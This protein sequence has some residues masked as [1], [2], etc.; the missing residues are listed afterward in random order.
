MIL[1]A[2]F[3]NASANIIHVVLM[4]YVWIVII[5][6]VLSWVNVPSL[7][8]VAIIL[9]YLTEPVMRPFRRIIPPQRLGGLDITPVIVILLILFV[10]SFI[11]KSISLYAQQLLREHA[12]SF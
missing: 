4:I 10:D 9:Y 6:A 5:R 11:V 7:H 12:L 3:L 8:Q 1:F 2:N